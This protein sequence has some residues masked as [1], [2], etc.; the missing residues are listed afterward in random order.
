MSENRVQE[1]GKVIDLNPDKK[2]NV[3]EG[4]KQ[5]EEQAKEDVKQKY[6]L[7]DFCE[8]YQLNDKDK[9]YIKRTGADLYRHQL[10]E[11]DEGLKP[12]RIEHE[13]L[14]LIAECRR[15]REE[16]NGKDFEINEIKKIAVKE[17]LALLDMLVKESEI[18]NKMNI[19]V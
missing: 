7:D 14:K 4:I 17:V 15:Y 6:W 19:V 10:E 2:E 18:L 16:I 12:L 9:N 8:R 5:I 3:Q 13:R 1:E 11:T